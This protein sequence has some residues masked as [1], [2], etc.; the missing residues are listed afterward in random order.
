MGA[1]HRYVGHVLDAREDHTGRAALRRDAYRS[2][3]AART[4]I[5]VSA[6]E[7]PPVARHSAGSESVAGA[8][9]RLIDTTTACA[10]QLDH[11][12]AE[13]P[14]PHAE[15]LATHLS[16]LDRAWAVPAR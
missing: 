13:L 4:A 1:A 7:L 5:D 14:S 10:V 2:L 8:V 15:L 3:A 12:A 16:E 11:R 6:A 9:E